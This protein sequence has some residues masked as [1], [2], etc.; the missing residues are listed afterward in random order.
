MKVHAKDGL[1]LNV[2]ASEMRHEDTVILVNAPGMSSAVAERLMHALGENGM[3]FA[4]WDLRGSPG[5]GE[6]FRAYRTSHHVDDLD[7]VLQALGPRRYVLASWCS[8]T[9]TALA[10]LVERKVTPMAFVAFCVPNFAEKAR[11]NL[12]GDTMERVC[13]IVVKDESKLEFLYEAMVARSGLDKVTSDLDDAQLRQLVLAPFKSGA[14]A[15]LRYAWAL[16]NRPEPREI[17]SWC[18]AVDVPMTFVG[19]KKDA[20]VSHLD[21]IELSKCS[22]TAKHVIFDDWNHYGLFYDMPTV[23][24]EFKSLLGREKGGVQ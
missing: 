1:P 17:R 14:Q 11:Y 5:E 22:A 18:A 24:R 2:L 3:N 19:G 16:M 4:T 15:M 21:S 12:A 7:A 13:A 10:A 8:G 9:P 20:M 23:I 6:E